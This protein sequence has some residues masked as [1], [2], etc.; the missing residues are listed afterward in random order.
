MHLFIKQ[1]SGITKK[2]KKIKNELS[3]CTTKKEDV[4]Y[5]RHP[6]FTIYKLIVYPNAT[7]VNN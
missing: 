3:V 1:R 4:T 7:S 2:N 5:K 6:P